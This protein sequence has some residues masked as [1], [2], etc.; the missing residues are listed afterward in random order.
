ML[1]ITVHIWLSGSVSVPSSVEKLI[2]NLLSLG[3]GLT[4]SLL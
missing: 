2:W 4:K 3:T 1:F